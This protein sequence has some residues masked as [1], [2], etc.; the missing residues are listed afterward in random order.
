MA[1]KIFCG[2]CGKIGHMYKTCNEPVIS[3]G[4]ILYR[5]K[6]KQVEYA[7]IRRKDSLG[8]V[9]FMRG[10]Y[11]T[12]DM[13]YIV[14]LF[15]EMTEEEQVRINEQSFDNLWSNLWLEDMYAINNKY[16]KEYIQSKYKFDILKK[17]NKLATFKKKCTYHWDTPEWGFPKGRRNI[18]ETDIRCATREFK[19]E[20]GLVDHQFFIHY[21]I[22][23]FIENFVGSNKV[24]YRHIYYLARVYNNDLALNIDQTKKSQVTEIGD[25]GWY[26]F[27]KCIDMI[28]DYNIE[29]KKMLTEV[30]HYILSHNIIEEDIS[31]IF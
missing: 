13:D 28:R 2:N 12:N 1:R 6:D 3:L 26:S 9:E 20:T 23:P 7:M 14:K 11:N 15:D 8:F 22:K 21:S 17:Q 4:I 25:I 27:D 31:N 24:N 30:N 10:N 29:K 18:K 5:W 19:E 16:K